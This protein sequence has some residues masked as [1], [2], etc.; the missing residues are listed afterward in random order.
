MPAKDGVRRDQEERRVWARK[1]A[2]ELGEQCSIGIGQAR[3]ANLA[4]EHVE[5]M[6]KDDDLDVLRGGGATGQGGELEHTPQR[7]VGEG[8]DHGL[9]FR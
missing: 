9:S 8:G 3:P 7:P 2:A 1:D 5:L 4:L 6:A